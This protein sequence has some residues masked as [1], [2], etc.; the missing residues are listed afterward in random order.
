[1]WYHP[2]I[3]NGAKIQV[4]QHN[5]HDKYYKK[6]IKKV[7]YQ[8]F[9]G[10]KHSST[11]SCNS[12]LGT[13]V[14]FQGLYMVRSPLIARTFH[15][16]PDFLFPTLSVLLSTM[17][18]CMIWVKPL[19]RH[20]QLLHRMTCQGL[21]MRSGIS[22]YKCCKTWSISIYFQHTFPHRCGEHRCRLLVWWWGDSKKLTVRIA[23]TWIVR[24]HKLRSPMVPWKILRCEQSQLQLC[25]PQDIKASS[26]QRSESLGILANHSHALHKLVLSKTVFAKQH[27]QPPIQQTSGW[28]M[29]HLSIH[30]SCWT[31]ALWHRGTKV[32]DVQN[33]PVA[34]CSLSIFQWRKP[35]R[36]SEPYW[37]QKARIGIS[38][39]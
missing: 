19:G 3:T 6:F 7:V 17:K 18:I 20:F 34:H 21:W 33:S 37:E 28:R 35:F 14:F 25:D 9:F 26:F 16:N 22:T 36:T 10:L 30:L 1:M 8:V 11:F 39:D 15:V 29:R 23:S 27:L 4:D 13:R 32:T 12:W 2:N 31:V 5:R 38:Q 24:A